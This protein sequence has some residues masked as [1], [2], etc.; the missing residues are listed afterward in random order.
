MSGVDDRIV[1]MKFDNMNFERKLSET[2]A[3]LEKLRKSLD[4]N[5]AT[6]GMQNLTTSANGV[7]LSNIANSVDHISSK[8]NA[9]TVVATAALTRLTHMAVDAGT[10]M[11]KAF[12]I[13]PLLDG[14]REFETNMN[15]IQTIL[16]N[17]K[18]KG[19]TL[20]DVNA[21]LDQL[22]QYS[23][24][25]I[26]NFSQMARN[27]GTFTAAG[28]GL[29]DSV[30]AI[31]GVANLA[32]ISGS[33]AEQA[34]TAMYQLSQAL[35][36]GKVNLMDWNSV[37]NAGMGGEIFKKAL[38]E[39]GKAMKTITDVPLTA[40]FEQWEKKGGTFREQMQKGW[41]TSDVLKTTLGAF[42][43]DLDKAS[44]SAIGFSDKAAQQMIDLGKLGLAAATEVK[45][46]TQLTSTVKESIASGWSQSF[47]TIIGDFEESKTLFT[48]INAGIGAMVN[49]SADRRNELLKGWKELGG[50]DTLIQGFENAVTALAKVLSPIRDAFHSIF[51][52]L[53]ATRLFA[54]TQKFTDFTK[55]LIISR[56]TM[57]TIKRIF[58]GVFATIEIGITVFKGI[59]GIIRQ[60]FS[61]LAGASG[62]I[63]D[64]AATTG[65][66]LVKLNEALVAGGGIERFFERISE[67]I[68]KPIE[69]IQQFTENLVA[70]FAAFSGAEVVE[71]S[72]E[73]ISSRFEHLSGVMEKLGERLESVR[74]IFDR[75]WTY[76]STWFKELGSKL[77][78]VMEPGDFNAAV[79]IVN[80]GLLGG[81]V[82]LLK[83]FLNGGIK[84]NIGNNFFD[85]VSESLDALTGKLKAMQA[86]LKAKALL[87]IAAAVGI[88]TI[89]MVAL[90]MIDSKALAKALTAIAVGFG[91]LITAMA[92]MDQ[93]GIGAFKFNL[94]A[95]GMI[96]L[97]T[98]VGVLS[99]AV[100]NL[101]TLDPDDL[102]K[103]LAGI[104]AMLTVLVTATKFISV[105]AA[106]LIAA[107]FAMIGISTALLILSQAVKAF[108]KLSWEEMAKGLIGVAVGLGAI[109]I[110]LKFMPTSYLVATGAALI[111]IATGLN[112]LAGAVKLFSLMS[113]EEMG[114]GLAGIGAALL[115][116][117]GAMH[118]MPKGMPAMAAG[119]LILSV[120]LNIMAVAIKVLGSMEVSEIAKG[121]GA[122]AGM[123]LILVVA[124]KHMTS[125]I[126]GAFALTIVVAAL[127]A[128][129]IILK[130]LAQ[131]SIAQIVTGLATIAGVMII[132][133][134]TA[135][136]LTPVIPLMISLGLAMILIAGAFTLFGIGAA[137]FGKAI[138]IIAKSGKAA[139]KAVIES[140][141]LLITAIPRIKVALFLFLL[142]FA[143][144]L[145][146]AIPLIIKSVRVILG[147][148]LE[149]VIEL[150]PKIAE[151]LAVIISEAL[152][153]MREQ[154]PDIV[155]TGFE[156]LI[157]L[158]QGVRDNI[159]E[160]GV[161]VVEILMEFGKALTDN[162]LLIVTAGTDLL[163]SFL[164]GISQNI[165]K[166]VDAVGTVIAEFIRAL[167]D[168]ASKIVTAG[169]DAIIS[170][171]DGIR[172]DTPRVVA[173][174]V[175][176]GLH[177]ADTFLDAIVFTVDKLGDIVIEFLD[178]LAIA[179]R[180]NN[181]GF[182]QAGLSVASAILSGVTFGLSDKAGQ[183]AKAMG[184]FVTGLI[185]KAKDTLDSNSPSKVF[186]KIGV[187]ITEGMAIGIAKDNSAENSVVTL[188][189][190]IVNS[191]QETLNKI[192]DSLAGLDDLNPVI[193]PVLDL[194]RVQADSKKLNRMMNI[195][196]IT[197]AVSFDNAKL[198]STTTDVASSESESTSPS[199]PSE[200]KFEQNIYSPTALSANDIY[201]STKSQIALAKEDLGIS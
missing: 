65:D 92:L 25:T 112:I 57:D 96:L 8:F 54:L 17:T 10:R 36:A 128:L 131:L 11:V 104:A 37:V 198:I 62:G 13:G 79:D 31:K 41:L 144:E 59:S 129:T 162:A 67:F 88:L 194:T 47:R 2:L 30:N 49:E 98:A 187:G 42:S 80:V 120:A 142:G 6:R 157:A 122:L 107:G 143:Q 23:D 111:L 114:Q 83:R 53:I 61:S 70:F 66:T 16:A 46:F 197:A 147:H 177:V 180:E 38:F 58:A 135:K 161:L 75:A 188:A 56:E 199:A 50:R 82:I 68:K 137:L 28:V 181:E 130:E 18:S 192:P 136:V 173:A 163:V 153:L 166:V 69:F 133:G 196:P 167:G 195:A 52:P 74:K 113:W 110:A 94:M 172:S 126:A 84:L 108:S 155:A 45:T 154:F 146:R 127:S 90:A 103:G 7:N 3:S 27:I 185:N 81:I 190:N 63:F 40:S 105:N 71:Q 169:A 193:T 123:L 60:V 109:V 178:N 102:A 26:Y 43:G 119:L 168:Q 21:A 9:M 51:P 176:T 139:I 24:K 184:G 156:M 99:L 100:K 200:I 33:N 124:M 106:G 86:D 150:V 39:T 85:K 35:A 152:L 22:N 149:T 64:F 132:L 182:R 29:K 134:L 158:L 32:A 101:S 48:N 201:R 89:S 125:A 34:S 93:L 165:S 145:L 148:I 164:S 87:K 4:F 183:G 186:M 78:A 73:R 55:S 138:E 140:L 14:F 1:S 171:L 189:E 15:S 19:A 44:L 191:F 91:Q 115:I 77:A 97:A 5:N 160:I 151:A 174:F 76:I 179:I 118:L 175:T 12:T 141:E 95:A 20:G 170:F 159:Y 121:L 117:A 116:I 72:T